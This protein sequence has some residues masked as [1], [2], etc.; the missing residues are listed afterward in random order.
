MRAQMALKMIAENEDIT[1]DKFKALKLSTHALLADRTLPDLLAAAKGDPD[2]EMQAAVKL[3]TE[4]D[5]SFRSDSR[6]AL[7]FEEW[8]RQF[9]GPR[10]VDVKNY[11]VPFSPEKATSTPSGIKD[12]AAAVT[13][14][15]KAIVSTKEKYGALDRPFGEVSRFKIGDVDVPGDAQVGGLGPFRVITWGPLDKDGKRY[16]QH[17]ETWVGMVEFSTPIKAYGLMSY[18]NSRQPGTTHN[19]DQL[20]MLSKHEFREFW[21]LPEQIKAHT[22]SVTPLTP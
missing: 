4:W 8:A 10:F 11:A 7:L 6:A 14:L 21:L 20:E 17:G 3:L 22:E 9:A 1:F 13:M 16:P 19:S 15:R 2:P 5:R 12:P 18:G